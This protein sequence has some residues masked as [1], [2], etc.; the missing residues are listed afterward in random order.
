MP[1]NRSAFLSKLAISRSPCGLGRRG[2]RRR[3][4]GIGLAVALAG[5][6]AMTV[7]AFGLGTGNGFASVQRACA[8]LRD[9]KAVAV[10][11]SLPTGVIGRFAVLR[12]APMSGDSPPA[13]A[14]RL[15]GLSVYDP[16]RVRLLA[17]TTGHS[18]YLIPGRFPRQVFTA[19]CRVA[20]A[21]LP[22]DQRAFLT[23]NLAVQR[24]EGF[25]GAL[26][27]CLVE[28]DRQPIGPSI[29]NE[30]GCETAAGRFPA[31][32]VDLDDGPRLLA[33]APD[34]VAEVR[35]TFAHTTRDLLPVASNLFAAAHPPRLPP[36]L[37]TRELR[38]LADAEGAVRRLLPLRTSWT[39]SLGRTSVSF[40]RP[41]DLADAVARDIY[42]ESR[43]LFGATR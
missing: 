3:W 32:D 43:Y 34:G 10:P 18:L 37:T 13:D 42:Y 23:A 15:A 31:F 28:V 27:L 26:V 9:G 38:S 17:T 19:R 20:L 41:H 1:A 8:G 30:V 12:R 11:G 33:L 4:I 36:L 7:A 24:L 22:A 16:S 40:R 35:I 6:S 21:R 14:L 2:G 25:N 5:S 29:S 39:N